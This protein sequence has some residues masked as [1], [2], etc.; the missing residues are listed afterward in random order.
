MGTTRQAV[1]HIFE[2]CQKCEYRNYTECT[3][4]RYQTGKI[5]VNNRPVWYRRGKKLNCP[6]D[7]ERE[8]T[9]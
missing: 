5:D 7:K 6:K 1:K 2:K 9:E 4:I 3:Y 8:V